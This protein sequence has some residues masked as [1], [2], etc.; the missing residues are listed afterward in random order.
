MISNLFHSNDLSG[1]QSANHFSPQILPLYFNS[2]SIENSDVKMLFQKN[3]IKFKSEHMKESESQGFKE[4]H[5]ENV[6]I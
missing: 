2:K 4:F 6:I 1:T 3:V 5:A